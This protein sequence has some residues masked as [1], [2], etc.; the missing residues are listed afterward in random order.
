METAARGI[1]CTHRARMDLETYLQFCKT[2]T[3]WAC[4]IC[5]KPLPLKDLVIDDKFT[6]LMN[7]LSRDA[8]QI[9]IH[10]NGNY[11]VLDDE[12]NVMPLP[13]LGGVAETA[14]QSAPGL[15]QQ[16]VSQH[17]LPASRAADFPKPSQ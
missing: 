13:L 14:A 2:S 7:R 6:E 10:S 8:K 17:K 11:E 5:N 4:P 12:D 9:K 16:P 1:N 3:D 15:Q